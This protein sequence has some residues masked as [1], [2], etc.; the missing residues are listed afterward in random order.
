MNGYSEQ[1]VEKLVAVHSNR[2]RKRNITSL[3]PE[4]E[5]PKRISMPYV[6]EITNKLKS[7]FKKHNFEIVHSSTNKLQNFIV[8]LKDKTKELQKS[9]IYEISCSECEEKYIGQTKRS[10]EVRFKE[11]LTSVHK[12]RAT[13]SAVALHALENNHTQWSIEN[14]K[15]KKQV[16]NEYK[17]DAYESIYMYL[18]RSIAMNTMEA[19][20]RSPLYRNIEIYGKHTV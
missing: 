7:V 19:P 3:T 15:L 11:H 16:N 8:Q 4:R 18:N 2:K 1:M 20:I 10:V 14:V 5:Q 12:R 17:L 6:P 13:K 9:G